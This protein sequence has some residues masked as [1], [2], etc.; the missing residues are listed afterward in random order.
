MPIPLAEHDPLRH[1]VSDKVPTDSTDRAALCRMRR[2]L[3]V[4]VAIGFALLLQGCDDELHA[5]QCIDPSTDAVSDDFR[6]KGIEM[7]DDADR[8]IQSNAPV[9]IDAEGGKR[10]YGRLNILVTP[11]D[12]YRI[13][14]YWVSSRSDLARAALSD[15][16]HPDFGVVRS[17]AEMT[18]LQFSFVS[19]AQDQADGDLGLVTSAHDVR[20]VFE[21]LAQSELTVRSP[22]ADAGYAFEVFL[23][24]PGGSESL[25]GSSSADM[26]L[27]VTVAPGSEVRVANLAAGAEG[28]FN[29]RI[30]GAGSLESE[31]ISGPE[32]VL[33]LPSGAGSVTRISASPAVPLRLQ[34]IAAPDCRAQVKHATLQNGRDTSLTVCRAAAGR[35][36]SRTLYLHP[37]RETFSSG[38]FRLTAGADLVGIGGCDA[39]TA[40]DGGT[41]CD[42][43]LETLLSGNHLVQAWYRQPPPIPPSP[44]LQ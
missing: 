35:M 10:F 28:R 8:Y 34:C 44:R 24:P 1:A 11:P 37:T 9:A 14:G 43:D 25:L 15:G 22:F 42:I 19:A 39:I 31:Q 16:S 17:A 23:T 38:T 20:V 32:L 12:G 4:G 26:P 29:Y 30:S 21:A 13:Q 5:V 33:Q 6:C 18:A 7:F 27:T 40:L 2:L 3:G 36:G 41:A